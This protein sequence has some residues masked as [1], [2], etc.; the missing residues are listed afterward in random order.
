MGMLEKAIQNYELSLFYPL[1]QKDKALIQMN[2]ANVYTIKGDF[3]T[4]IIY[5]NKVLS[6]ISILDGDNELLLADIYYNIGKAYDNTSQHKL[7]LKYFLLSEKIRDS[8]G[9]PDGDTYF[10]CA[11]NFNKLGMKDTANMFFNKAL[12]F[13][14]DK[15]GKN[16]YSTAL[17]YMNYATFLT[18]EHKYNEGLKLYNSSLNILEKSVGNKHLYTSFCY[19][20][21]GELYFRL[22]NYKTSLEYFQKSLISKVY[23]YY[24][25]SIY[26]NPT[27]KTFSNIDI[28]EVL[29][30]KAFSFEKL[31][32]TENEEKNLLAAFNTLELKIELV[33]QLRTGYLYENAKLRLSENEEDTYLALIRIAGKLYHNTKMPQYAEAAFKYSEKSKY[34]VLRE[35]FSEETLMKSASIP[36]S[37]YSKLKI[38][39]EKLSELRWLLDNENN[40]INPDKDKINT[41]EEQLFTHTQ[42]LE[43]FSKNLMKDYPGYMKSK[44]DNEVVTLKELQSGLR[45]DQVAFE[46]AISDSMLYTFF[47]SKSKFEMKH[48]KLEDQYYQNLSYYKSYLTS[49]DW[50]NY[51]SF[52]ISAYFLYDIFLKY[53][54][55]EIEGKSLLIIPDEDFALISFES[56]IDKPYIHTEDINS[57]IDPYI[58]RKYPI[59]YAFSASLYTEAIKRKIKK[60]NKILAIATDYKLSGESD[61]VLPFLT[62]YL[63]RLTFIGGKFYNKEDATESNLK[64]RITDYNIIHIYAHGQEDI[65]NPSNSCIILSKIN[66]SINDGFLYAHEVANLS[67][68]AKLVVLGSCY[69]GS[70][71]ISEG[72]GVMSI[73]RSFLSAGTSSIIMSLW[74]NYLEVSVEQLGSFHKYLLVGY[75]K[76]IALQKAKL[77]YLEKADELTGHPKEWASLVLTGNQEPLYHFF[78]AKT[79]FL[80]ALFLLLFLVSYRVIK[81]LVRR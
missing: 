48:T 23:D 33:E 49:F 34:S 39:R 55:K 29:S 3:N 2:I 27:S 54:E 16:H 78:F 26:S 32:I 41:L 57:A 72:E 1:T 18:E 59:G 52:R 6:I 7:A 61:L 14:E 42:A 13:F 43:S 73:G 53:F 15:Y 47:I 40:Q 71:K 44:Y 20:N 30:G 69:S 35:F 81:R 38:I 68:D 76:D 63:R 25:T 5:Y 67:L 21:L 64:S 77:N 62:R 8:V 19:K 22:K 28:L 46:Y 17:A 12:V 60:H 10:N 45:N 79:I 58:I 31:A 24:D 51:D 50:L 70:G 9:L 65:I 74:Y 56:L 36:D 11:T 37:L 75:R 80:A 4:A 66:D